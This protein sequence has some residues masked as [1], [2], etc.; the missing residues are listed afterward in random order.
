MTDVAMA[1]ATATDLTALYDALAEVTGETETW[2]RPVWVH[3]PSIMNPGG[4]KMSKRDKAKAARA[5][6]ASA[7][8]LQTIRGVHRL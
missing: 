2:Q 6:C 4:S 3:T 8:F 7:C 1:T 5:A